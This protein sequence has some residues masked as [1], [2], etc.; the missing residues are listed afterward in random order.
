MDNLE[1]RMLPFESEVGEQQ[2]FPSLL[3]DVNFYTERYV[4]IN[5]DKNS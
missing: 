5:S 2:V 4:L 3:W 1:K